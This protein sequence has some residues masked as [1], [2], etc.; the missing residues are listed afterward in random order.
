M[1][2]FKKKFLLTLHLYFQ[3]YCNKC[4][5][6]FAQIFHFKEHLRRSH[7]S[8]PN[9]VCKVC[10][11]TFNTPERIRKHTID[12]QHMHKAFKCHLCQFVS[13]EKD[14][15]KKHLKAAHSN[16]LSECKSCDMIFGNGLAKKNH[17]FSQHPFDEF[18]M[19]R[20][21]CPFCPA[22]FGA[23][24]NLTRHIRLKHDAKYSEDQEYPPRT[25]SKIGEI[26]N[27][28]DRDFKELFWG[29]SHGMMRFFGQ[30]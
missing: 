12:H 23:K 27:F 30:F 20:L 29:V 22:K 28:Y 15:I 21:S 4:D 19:S 9:P 14:V 7:A 6:I 10:G 11:L 1:T 5:I 16:T 25:K 3:F 24:N 13:N 26:F 17:M 18:Y 8:E 2:Y